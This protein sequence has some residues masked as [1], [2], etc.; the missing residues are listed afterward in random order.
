MSVLTKTNKYKNTTLH[1]PKF[2][3]KINHELM[4]YMHKILKTYW[5]QGFTD[6]LNNNENVYK[7]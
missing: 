2:T 3:L 6:L 5:E 4:I 1:T 7:A